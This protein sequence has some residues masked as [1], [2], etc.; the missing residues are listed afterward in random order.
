VS[1]TWWTKQ[2]EHELS[3]VALAAY[4]ERRERLLSAAV[5]IFRQEGPEAPVAHIAAAANMGM[6]SFYRTFAGRDELL[7]ALAEARVA[8]WIEGWRRALAKEDPRE[9]LVEA[10]WEFGELEQRDPA[11]A[12]VLRSRAFARPELMGEVEALGVEVVA[13][14]TASGTVR[15]DVTS[16]DVTRLFVMLGAI[17][18]TAD[19][20]AWRRVIALFVDALRP[21]GT[22]PLAS[23]PA[24]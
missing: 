20:V 17:E 11:L 4:R 12:N 8:L 10:L 19:D 23:C 3:P 5:A 24:T 21:G 7:D 16:D 18:R 9:A 6:S 14:A 2:P 13:R 15:A 22:T 1:R